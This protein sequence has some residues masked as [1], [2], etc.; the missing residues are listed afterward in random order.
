MRCKN[1]HA[2]IIKPGHIRNSSDTE[3]IQKWPD[4]MQC[5]IRRDGT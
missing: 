5:F 4:D 3:L 2:K 1:R